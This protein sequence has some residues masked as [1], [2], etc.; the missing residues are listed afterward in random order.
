MV[1][2]PCT[3]NLEAVVEVTRAGDVRKCAHTNKSIINNGHILIDDV[4]CSHNFFQI[5]F[6]I[7]YMD[8][9]KE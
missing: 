7:V 8:A 4:L 3:R 1:G 9:L 5:G 6:Y 2:A